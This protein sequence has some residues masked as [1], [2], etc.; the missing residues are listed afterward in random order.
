MRARGI[1]MAALGGTLLT[2]GM[3]ATASAQGGVGGL[4]PGGSMVPYS[5][6]E[7][8]NKLRFGINADEDWRSQRNFYNREYRPRYYFYGHRN[9]DRFLPGYRHHSRRPVLDYSERWPADAPEYHDYY[10]DDFVPLRSRSYS[11]PSTGYNARL[12]RSYNWR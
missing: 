3:A 9:E 6:T 12:Y 11:Y 5:E 4:A 7:F 2:T 10:E 8:R 1:L